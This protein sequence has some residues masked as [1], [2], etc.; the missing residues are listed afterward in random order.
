MISDVFEEAIIEID[1]YLNEPTFKELY[2]GENLEDILL[3]KK[4]MLKRFMI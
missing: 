1:E 4:L 3:I 2:S